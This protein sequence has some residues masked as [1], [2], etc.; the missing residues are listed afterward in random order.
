MNTY[1]AIDLN[2]YVQTG[3]GGTALTYSHKTRN[4]LAKLYKPGFEA[5][6]AKEEFQTALIVFDLGLPTPEP[7]RL[8]T[9]G[10]R[11]G[12]EYELIKHKRSFT[13]IIS[14]EPSRLE[15]ISVE[16]ARMAKLLHATK[17]DTGRMKSIV[18]VLKRF[19]LE[20][21]LV[22]D[23]FKQRAFSFLDRV[24]EVPTCLHGDLHIGNIIT[25]GKRTLWIDVGQFC[26]G[27]PEWDLGWMWT[28]CN[29]MKAEMADNLL[30]LTHET[31][32]AHWNI[33]IAAY[34]GTDDS[35]AIGEF[36]KRILS[37][38]A[39][40]IPYMYDLAYHTRLPEAAHKQISELIV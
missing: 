17:A 39:V 10:E 19:Y 26:Y 20:K 5:D 18:Q 4:V 14:E 1:E 3:E 36:T 23:Y 12:T 21:D 30:H 25:D 6:V 29:R 11:V 38:Y 2:E 35:K 33:F 31:L 28:I 32:K 24:D 34:L 7:Y 22:P 13:R 37:Y 27:A 9:D 16:F 8:I 15:E 40:K